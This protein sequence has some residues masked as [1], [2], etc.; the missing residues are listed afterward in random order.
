MWDLSSWTRDR[1]CTSALE[2]GFLTTEPPGKSFQT[3][4]NTLKLCAWS[5]GHRE[6][7][8]TLFVGRKWNDVDNLDCPPGFVLWAGCLSVQLPAW[9]DSGTRKGS[10]LTSPGECLQRHQSPVNSNQRL[11]LPG[12]MKDLSM[13]A[14][15][16]NTAWVNSR[17]REFKEANTFQEYFGQWV[18][19]G[20]VKTGCIICR[21][22][23]KKMGAPCS[24]MMKNFKLVMSR[25][26]NFHGPFWF[27]RGWGLDSW[28]GCCL[29]TWPCWLLCWVCRLVVLSRGCR[30]WWWCAC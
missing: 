23:G 5:S 9:P 12:Q 10:D 28:A 26:L 15:Q 17:K 11:P 16:A 25:A 19:V 29:W 3:F 2:G 4:F 13:P 1:T 7:L 21:N 14:L 30:W 22:Q 6:L 20:V 18:F 27:G 24:I 8:E